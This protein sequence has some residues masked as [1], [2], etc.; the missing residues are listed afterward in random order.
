MRA[1]LHDGGGRLERLRRPGQT[2][3]IKYGSLVHLMNMIA[4]LKLTG[5]EPPKVFF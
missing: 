2:F 5:S 3:C 4:N 1:R